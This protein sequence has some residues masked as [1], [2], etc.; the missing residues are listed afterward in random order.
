MQAMENET[1]SINLINIIYFTNMSWSVQ[2]EESPL[3]KGHLWVL[4]FNVQWKWQAQL[5]IIK[6]FCLL[7]AA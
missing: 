5:F 1:F 6:L 7:R 3:L 2:S 4:L